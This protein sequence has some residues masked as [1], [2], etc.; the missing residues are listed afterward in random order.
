MTD[1]L[2][3]A[4][5][6]KPRCPPRHWLEAHFAGEPVPPETREHLDSCDT[7]RDQLRELTSA[8]AAYIAMRPPELFR[9]QVLRRQPAASRRWY[10]F[11]PALATAAAATAGL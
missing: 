4:S 7:C 11:A 9:Q 2:L 1:D 3:I 5:R 8:S 10:L 6:E